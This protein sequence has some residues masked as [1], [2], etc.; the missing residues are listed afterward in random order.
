MT[1]DD[2]FKL[3]ML[4]EQLFLNSVTGLKEHTKSKHLVNIYMTI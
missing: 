4:Q 2:L 3:K 1:L